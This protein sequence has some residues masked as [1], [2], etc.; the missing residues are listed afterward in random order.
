MSTKPHRL[1]VQEKIGYGLGDTASN[2]FFFGVNAWIFFYYTEICKIHPTTVGT[3]LLLPRFW[4]AISDPLMGALADRTRTRH[5]TYRPYLLWLAI[6]FG[7]CGYLTFANPQFSEGGKLIY[8]Y[9]TYIA[10]MSAY[11]AINVPY[12]ALMGV[13]TSSSSERTSLSTYRF[14]GAFSGQLII[15]MTF[16]PMVMALGGGDKGVGFPRAM[17]LLAVVAT[18]MFLATFATTRERIK[19][20]VRKNNDLRGDLG[21]LFRNTP[22]IIMV[23]AAILTLSSAAVRWTIT[24]QYLK[25]YFGVGDEKFFLFLDKISFV[26]T[27]G[28]IAFIAGV[29]FTGMLTRRFGKRNSLMA[30]TLINGVLVV[31]LFLIPRDGYMTLVVLNIVGNFLAGPTPA[32]VWSIYTDVADYGEWKSGRRVTG[33]A[34]SAAMFSQKLG[35][36]IGGSL[37]GWILGGVGFVPD[38]PPSEEVLSSFRV[39]AT[40]LPGSLAIANGIVLIWY[41]LTEEQMVVVERELAEQRKSSSAE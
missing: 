21:S 37:C 13:M 27:T 32:L 40:V 12:S 10:L 24:P 25:Y 22:W 39:I 30:L 1:P 38:Q 36:T 29:F 23:V 35:I 28:S 4:D 41:K 18:L 2:I 3:L 31:G 17:G 34:F 14:V 8:A 20:Q 11:T 7:I 15:S 19:P 16:L 26:Q 9:I 5:G 6:P 33:L